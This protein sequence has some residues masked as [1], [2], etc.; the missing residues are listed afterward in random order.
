MLQTDFLARIS[1]Q[2]LPLRSARSIS[3]SWLLSSKYARNQE[4]VQS[5]VRSFDKW[6]SPKTSEALLAGKA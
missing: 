6:V 5:Y 3:S 4:P 2:P 1:N